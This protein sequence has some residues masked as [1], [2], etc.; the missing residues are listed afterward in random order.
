MCVSIWP[1]GDGVVHVKKV[2]LRQAWLV[3]RCMTVRRYAALACSQPSRSTQ[4]PTLSGMG[5]E[6]RPKCDDALSPVSK[7]RHDSFHL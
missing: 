6:Y 5:N 3:L 4:P 7:D 2:A 1:N